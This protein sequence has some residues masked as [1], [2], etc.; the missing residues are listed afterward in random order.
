MFDAGP[1]SGNGL[2]ATQKYKCGDEIMREYAAMRL[3]N[4]HPASSLEA[5]QVMH[6]Q[7]AQRA[8]NSMHHTT[9]TAFMDLSSCDEEEASKTPY[10]IYDTN[11]FRLEDG[12]TNDGALFLTIARI[13]HSCHPNVNHIWRDDLQ[14]MLVFACRDIEIGDEVFTS[15]GPGE[16]MT[17]KH[18][19][20]YLNDRF[21]FEC[22]CTMCMEGNLKGGD[23]RMVEIQSLQQD[24]ALSSMI[25]KDSANSVEK[26]LESVTKC[27]KLMEEQGIGRGVYTKTI[28]HHGYTLCMAYD[29]A[30][31]AKSF[32]LRELKAVQDSEGVDSPRAVEIEH[33]LNV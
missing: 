22:R 31:G 17:T 28:Y 24:I 29:D 25:S 4:S 3:P 21:S 7:A 30:E 2:R 10:G 26:S 20:E 13:N 8:Y 23:E 19:R 18:R 16:C 12:K 11:S 32:L 33:V 15:Y 14:Q 9:K 6:K 5:A 1:L 27:L